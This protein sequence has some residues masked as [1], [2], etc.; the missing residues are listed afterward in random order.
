M[1]KVDY[2]DLQIKV[3]LLGNNLELQYPQCLE[4]KEVLSINDKNNLVIFLYH[5]ILG[6]KLKILFIKR[7]F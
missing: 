7:L 5:E 1:D 3:N 2:K 4:L 6:S